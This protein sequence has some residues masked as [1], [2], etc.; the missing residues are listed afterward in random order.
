MKKLMFIGLA[1]L[2][3]ILIYGN[4][5]VLSQ[6]VPVNNVTINGILSLP[7]NSVDSTK[8]KPLSISGTDIRADAID[9]SKVR[10]LSLSGSDLVNPLRTTADW[11][12]NGTMTV[13]G[14]S[15]TN[16]KTIFQIRGK[17][18]GQDTL[19]SFRSSLGKTVGWGD[20]L[21]KFYADTLRTINGVASGYFIV[22]GDAIVRGST[23]LATTTVDT[24]KAVNAS[25]TGYAI[26]NGQ[27]I[28][29]ANQTLKGI[30]TIDT[31][32]ATN[33][34]STGYNITNGTI[35]GRAGETITGTAASDTIHTTNSVATGYGILN[36][37]GIF[38]GGTTTTGIAT[39][40]TV[41][42]TNTVST[43]YNIT[44]G[45]GI[46]RGELTVTNNITMDAL[47]GSSS[48]VSAG[49]TDGQNVLTFDVEG[50]DAGGA[51]IE[52]INDNNSAQMA[53]GRT[54]GTESSYLTIT[55]GGADNLPG[56]LSLYNDGGTGE[57]VWVNSNN[58]LR[59]ATS[60]PADDDADGFGIID[61]DDG[62][63][64]G[65][66]LD[67]TKVADGSISNA[68]LRN[69]A[70]TG[71]KIQASAIDST[72]VKDGSLSVSDIANGNNGFLTR[73]NLADSL[74]TDYGIQELGQD[75]TITG[76]FTAASVKGDSLRMGADTQFHRDSANKIATD[77]TLKAAGFQVAEPLKWQLDLKSFT[78][79]DDDSAGDYTTYAVGVDTTQTITRN[80][81]Y[82]DFTHC[83]SYSVQSITLSDVI[84]NFPITNPDSVM[85]DIFSHAG[86]ADSIKCEVRIKYGTTT[87]FN[88]GWQTPSAAMAW[89]HFAFVMATPFTKDQEYEVFIDVTGRMANRL[90]ISGLQFK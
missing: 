19:F 5:Y 2:S 11:A 29:R 21:G 63:W 4:R 65:T 23:Y 12:L 85:V 64:Q 24:I 87:V 33:T 37:V 69:D 39:A 51:Y 35:I 84:A 10:A 45:A 90:L 14:T 83:N 41:H 66:A 25:V 27:F 61:L 73:P 46:V 38:R 50:T 78:L 72:D 58:I 18:A 31:I 44:N 82:L 77:D 48:I 1:V 17:T 26:V 47:A 42:S 76:H 70:V 75:W 3:I 68:D 40:D 32:N 56:F 16:S 57:W 8:I 74:A 88:S 80:R 81:K 60:K 67:S 6:G 55:D 54:T 36:G 52:F 9:S 20:S 43:G 30:A 53:V 89:E 62:T 71:G 59:G 15:L 49:S 7:N 28:A 22:N 86:S 34:V 79:A 13:G